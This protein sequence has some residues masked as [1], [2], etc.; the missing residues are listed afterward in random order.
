MPKIPL[1]NPQINLNVPGVQAPFTREFG[2][3]GAGAEMAGTDIRDQTERLNDQVQQMAAID[4]SSMALASDK[5]ASDQ[6]MVEL[7][8]SSSDGLLRDAAG[9]IVRDDQKRPKT[10]VD[11]YH[12]WADQRFQAAQEGMPGGLAQRMYRER[13]LSYYSNETGQLVD[14]VQQARVHA[15][16]QNQ[17]AVVEGYGN[18][19][20]SAPALQKAYSYFDDVAATNTAM[21]GVAG[22]VY[23][24]GQ[25]D[26]ETLI[27]QRKLG[28]QLMNG[29]YL[30]VLNDKKVNDPQ[31]MV[32]GVHEWLDIL[33]GNDPI[34]QLR[35]Q[36]GMT[37][38]ASSMDP[39]QKFEQMK[40]LESLL[41][42]A[43]EK[44]W[45]NLLQR[46]DVNGQAARQGKINPLAEK[47]L[48]AEL[49]ADIQM[50]PEH[51][52]TGIEAVGHY[53]VQSILGAIPDKSFDRLPSG[54]KTDWLNRSVAHADAILGQWVDHFLPGNPQAQALKNVGYATIKKELTERITQVEAE[55]NTDSAAFSK[56]VLV[57]GE[58]IANVR[59]DSQA[60]FSQR[61]A[62]IQAFDKA[63]YDQQ[64][65]APP[66]DTNKFRAPITHE[67]SQQ[68][69]EKISNSYDLNTPQA[70]QYIQALARAHGKYTNQVFDQL[71]KDNSLN[72]SGRI[73]MMHAKDGNV[74]GLQALVSAYRGGAEIDGA[75]KQRYESVNGM[76][77][78]METRV[79]DQVASQFQKF[80]RGMS[81]N[82]PLG[83]AQDQ[84]TSQIMKFAENY[85]KLLMNKDQ[86]LTPEAAVQAAKHIIIDRDWHTLTVGGSTLSPM[87]RWNGQPVSPSERVTNIVMPNVVN[88]KFRTPEDMENL[89]YNMAH[90]TS[91][92]ESFN[93][94]PPLD[95]GGV[96]RS[97]KDNWLNDV[98]TNGNWHPDDGRKGYVYRYD[99]TDKDGN[100]VSDIPLEYRDS[101]G[102]R[103]P[104]VIPFEKGFYAHPTTKSVPQKA[105]DAVK[106]VQNSPAA[107]KAGDMIQK[108]AK[109][110]EDLGVGR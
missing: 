3:V 29:V 89:K 81:E 53:N 50:H 65:H 45:S 76:V 12:E 102:N 51:I 4:S 52:W 13:A 60:G 69:G 43:K 36:H 19:L 25:A 61:G 67:E 58:K 62:D 9:N 15:A 75:F 56:R 79:R 44:D 94:V 106:A 73:L 66:S 96:P 40:H 54:A 39:Q 93:P 1:E 57:Q 103:H 97:V 7:K 27:A 11:A 31:K 78:D 21:S 105:A 68:I 18:D 35:K 84:A 74:S 46:I 34:S 49:A 99:L 109:W 71:V 26:Q 63:H 59:Y 5:I 42:M 85:S 30:N 2:K 92:L 23:N 100:K 86:S 38:L 6:K 108:A 110:L 70:A 28:N 37:T 72:A 101:H 24:K 47:S 33:R 87:D 91:T 16:Q 8:L 88:G 22:G 32:E 82:Y 10:I 77:K 95:H 14:H 83:V 104:I 17:A 55:K 48:S 80:A 64:K 20:V 98:K 90:W 41:P 107:Q